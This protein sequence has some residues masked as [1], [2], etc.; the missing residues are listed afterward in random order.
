VDAL[1]LW[2]AARERAVDELSRRA[3]RL[4]RVG[5]K[6]EAASLRGAARILRLRV[7]QEQTQAEAY[8]ADE[9]T[10]AREVG[11]RGYS[12]LYGEHTSEQGGIR[13]QAGRRGRV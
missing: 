8:E 13:R 3:E 11:G 7:I 6:Q 2:V 4:S 1:R 10:T 12:G 5:R 9:T